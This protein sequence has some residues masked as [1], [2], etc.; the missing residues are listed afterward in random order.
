MSA[1]DMYFGGRGGGGETI[2][3]W[4]SYIINAMLNM[5]EMIMISSEQDLIKKR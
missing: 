5:N 3:E 4:L 2:T 1:T